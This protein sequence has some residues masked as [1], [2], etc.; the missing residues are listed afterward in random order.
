MMLLNEIPFQDV[1]SIQGYV[2]IILKLIISIMRVAYLFYQY[3]MNGV[4][5]MIFHF[6]NLI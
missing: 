2:K 6:Q 4:I 3:Y 5:L 1:I